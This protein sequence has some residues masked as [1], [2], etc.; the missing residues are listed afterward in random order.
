MWPGHELVGLGVFVCVFEFGSQVIL[1]RNWNK[2]LEKQR[3]PRRS[4]T[5][6]LWVSVYVSRL[7]SPLRFA[8]EGKQLTLLFL[9]I[10]GLQF[11]EPNES[12][13]HLG[14]F[15]SLRSRM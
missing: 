12:N 7:L 11:L 13:T 5:L 10:N 4:F 14:L 8:Q 2:Q 3:E 15:Q 6:P 1:I 9:H